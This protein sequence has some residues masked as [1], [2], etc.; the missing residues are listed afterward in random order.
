M[1]DVLYIF[2]ISLSFQ[3]NNS[4]RNKTEESKIKKKTFNSRRLQNN[5]QNENNKFINH[6]LDMHCEM[7]LELDVH[8]QRNA[9][10]NYILC[11]HRTSS[12]RPQTQDFCYFKPL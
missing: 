9:T 1:Y 5:Y 6:R 11:E 8:D 3:Q 7:H 10:L 2:A 4:S 12:R